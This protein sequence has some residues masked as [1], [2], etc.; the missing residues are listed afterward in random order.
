MPPPTLL[1][2]ILGTEK[3][4]M[5][6][7]TLRTCDQ[8]VVIRTTAGFVGSPIANVRHVQINIDKTTNSQLEIGFMSSCHNRDKVI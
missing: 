3:D 5:V 1:S 8:S 2:Y 4:P 6:D 7:T